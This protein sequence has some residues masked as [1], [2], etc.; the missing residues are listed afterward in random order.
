MEKRVQITE[1]EWLRRLGRERE[2]NLDTVLHKENG[3]KER[4]E[5]GKEESENGRGKEKE[6]GEK[7]RKE[8][9][10]GTAKRRQ[11]LCKHD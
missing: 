4:E 7:R 8:M 6:G 2:R 11:I 10:N 1:C 3:I 9:T 5:K